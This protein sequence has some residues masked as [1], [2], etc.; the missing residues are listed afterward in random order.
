MRIKGFLAAA[1]LGAALHAGLIEQGMPRAAGT[2]VK[3]VA[4]STAS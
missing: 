3:S 1:L 4:A 2:P